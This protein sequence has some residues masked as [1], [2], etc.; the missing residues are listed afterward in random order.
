MKAFTNLNLDLA[1]G[2]RIYADKAYNSYEYE[3]FLKD[4][5]L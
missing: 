3:D 4:N 2:A 5:G 1:Q